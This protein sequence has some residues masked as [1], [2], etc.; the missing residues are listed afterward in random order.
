MGSLF[1]LPP[2]RHTPAF[3]PPC[4]LS[5]SLREKRPRLP[6][7]II[8]FY[9]LCTKEASSGPHAAPAAPYRQRYGA[10]GREW[11]GAMIIIV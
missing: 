11:G 2:P 6:R 7:I 3:S 5:F 4:P 8:Y 10:V 1:S 9:Y